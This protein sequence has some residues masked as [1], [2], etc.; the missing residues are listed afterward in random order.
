MRPIVG[1]I[2]HFRNATGQCR[3][4]IVTQINPN[5]SLDLSVFGRAGQILAESTV[6][7]GESDQESTWHWPEVA[8][9]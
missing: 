2:V 3:A 5:G 1:S 7:E 6:N 4:A 9:A 8:E